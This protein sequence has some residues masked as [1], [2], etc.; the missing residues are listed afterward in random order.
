M[1]RNDRNREETCPSRSRRKGAAGGGGGG[2]P[3]PHFQNPPSLPQPRVR[4]HEAILED[5]RLVVLVLRVL[6]G[7]IFTEPREAAIRDLD[8]VLAV[9]E[10]EDE[11]HGW[12]SLGGQETSSSASG[13]IVPR[14]RSARLEGS[15][16]N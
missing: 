1:A 2:G 9:D 6:D 4:E 15:C 13:R 8:R 3:T 5:D 14:K 16:G 12:S 11:R 10:V 7:P